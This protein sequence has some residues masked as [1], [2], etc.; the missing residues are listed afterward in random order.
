MGIDGLDQL[1]TDDE[2][3]LKKLAQLV[4][5]TL[6]TED[7]YHRWKT[8]GA[9]AVIKTSEVIEKHPEYQ[10]LTNSDIG[11]VVRMVGEL[12]ADL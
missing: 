4:R 9:W 10:T 8:M 11:T 12:I 6:S 1:I 5:E 2:P 7:D 3:S